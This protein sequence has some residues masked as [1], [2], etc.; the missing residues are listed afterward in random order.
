M[1]SDVPSSDLVTPFSYCTLANFLAKADGQKQQ[2]NPKNSK[3]TRKVTT[4]ENKI[5]NNSTARHSAGADCFAL[6]AS[7]QAQTPAALP[8]PAPDGAYKGFNIAEGFDA[9]L[10][11]TSG[12]WNTA[13]GALTLKAD[14]TGSFNTAVGG[15][16]LLKNTT[17]SSNTAV[18]VNALVSNTTGSF[19]MA[20]GQGALGSNTTGSE[21]TAMGYQALNHNN[22]GGNVAVG[23]QALFTNTIG[24]SNTAMGYQA[25]FLN[26][27]S[28]NV[29]VGTQA[30]LLNTT[31][32][33]NT[34]TG[35]FALSDNRTG[36]NNTAN[37]Y[38]AL[39]LN[40]TGNDNTATGGSALGTNT[41]GS[42]NTATGVLALYNNTG[43]NNIAFGFAAGYNLT[44][45]NKN[46]Y[47]GNAAVASESTTTRIGSVQTRTFIAGIR[48]R[49]TGVAN[50]VPV[51]IDS[52]D[53]L[54]TASS[55]RRFKKEIK[56]MDQTSEAILGLKPVTF[57]YKSDSTNT[58]Q[59]GLIAEEVAK[60]NPDLVV[61]DE[62]GEIYTVRYD[63]V[64][65]MLLNEF[66]KEHRKMEEQGAIIT[67]QQ[68]QIEALTA[69]LQKVTDQL[70]L[71]RPAP[72]TVSNDR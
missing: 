32:T 57:H 61:R 23:T 35:F 37:G 13:L 4:N 49:T 64:N 42:S 51:L 25:L 39:Q 52:A 55:S 67:K 47:I 14:T 1:Q 28:G 30:L 6:L 68:K 48:G 65:A 72:Q 16:A 26:N 33:V 17:G 58:P 59:F 8:S 34:A 11:L 18:G 50:A 71:S 69:G 31:G 24:L 66:L 20:L 54:G 2:A 36:G 60:A 10:G 46:I 22:A 53:Q 19:N 70:E 27:A 7:A 15:Q 12:T 56:P 45:G 38:G 9:L 43:S 3:L 40:T 21:N 44:T 62:N 5:Q 29:A 41:I 63:A